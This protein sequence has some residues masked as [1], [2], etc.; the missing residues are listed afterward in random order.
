MVPGPVAPLHFQGL[1]DKWKWLAALFAFFGAFASF[2]IGNMTQ[3]NS[4]AD[5]LAA[6]FSIPHAVTGIVILVL[7]G[8]VIVGGIKRIAQVTEK[9]VPF[10]AIFY[11]LG[12][13]IILATRIT[14]I[15]EA[16]ALIFR[17]AFTPTA[18]V[19]GL[20]VP[21]SARP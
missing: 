13:L 10:M 16:F 5:V 21:L 18:A 2:G 3:A 14:A 4:M 6:N 11:V 20:P 19:G 12:G 9:L 1:G 8:L 15:P 17:H 7:A